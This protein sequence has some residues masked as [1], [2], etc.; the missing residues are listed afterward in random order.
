[1]IKKYCIVKIVIYIE[2]IEM[3]IILEKYELNISKMSTFVDSAMN[4][5]NQAL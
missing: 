1:M 4:K 5:I 2:Q 3:E